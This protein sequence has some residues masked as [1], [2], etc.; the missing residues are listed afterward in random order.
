M[1]IYTFEFKT[2][3]TFTGTIETTKEYGTFKFNITQ[4]EIVVSDPYFEAALS[5]A[6]DKVKEA[7]GMVKSPEMTQTSTLT[8]IKVES[9]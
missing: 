6:Y 2:S 9:V 1:P 4:L 8:L 7:I 3:N 5:K